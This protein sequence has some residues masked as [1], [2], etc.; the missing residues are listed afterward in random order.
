MFNQVDRQ[1]RGKSG[2]TGLGWAISKR[3]I[4]MMGGRIGVDSAAG[5]GSTF[6]F[7]LPLR[8]G[9]AGSSAIE[10]ASAGAIPSGITTTQQTS[11][12]SGLHILVADDNPVNQQV[13][14]G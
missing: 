6:W 3:L 5:R 7:T 1:A 10:P 14:A 13:A 8:P 4:A 2:G 9:L 11:I 12:V